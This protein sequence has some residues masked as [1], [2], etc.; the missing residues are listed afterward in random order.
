MKK[1]VTILNI[2][3]V[4]PA[5]I[6][7]PLCPFAFILIEGEG[8]IAGYFHENL[9]KTLMVSYPVILMAGVMSSVKLRKRNYD[10]WAVF[11]AALPSV[12]STS[13]VLV[14]LF[15]GIQLR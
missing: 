14:Y 6:I 4:I 10:G 3:A 9:L 12:I 13:I 11:M 8:T 5:L 15:G 1:A 2:L 7:L